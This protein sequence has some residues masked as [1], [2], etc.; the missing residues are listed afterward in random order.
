MLVEFRLTLI[1][2]G[3]ISE[4]LSEIVSISEHLKS[5]FNQISTQLKVIEPNA[6]GGDYQDPAH[7]LISSGNSGFDCRQLTNWLRQHA[8]L[9]LEKSTKQTALFL[10]AA[11]HQ[12]ALNQITSHFLEAC[13]ALENKEAHS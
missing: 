12:P 10:V 4:Q 13:T 8:H 3:V 5:E 9:D 6:I 1:E 7:L 2:A 11:S